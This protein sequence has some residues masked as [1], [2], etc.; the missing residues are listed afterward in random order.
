MSFF[1]ELAWRGFIQDSSDAKQVQE[2]KSGDAF[3]LG[4]DAT[5]PSIHIGHFIPIIA[6][7]HMAKAGLKPVILIGGATGAIG[8]PRESSER[9]LIAEEQVDNSVRRIQ[10][11]LDRVFARLGI[12]VTFVNNKD[13]LSGISFLNFLRDVG[14]HFPVATMI[15]KDVIKRRLNSDGISYT[16]FSYQLLQAY[17]F[18]HLNQKFGVKLQI[19]GSD[20][21]GNVTAGLDFI[22][23]KGGSG[24]SGFTVPLLTDSNGKKLGKSEGNALWIDAELFSPFQ[25]HQYFLNQSD[26]D[27]EGFLKVFTFKSESEISELLALAS[28]APEKRIVQNVVADSFVELIHGKDAVDHAKKSAEVLFSGAVQD[29]SD[30]DLLAIFAHVPSVSLSKEDLALASVLDLL[31]KSGAVKSRGD[32]KRLVTGGGVSI[33]GGRVEDAS[34]PLGSIERSIVIIRTGKKSYHLVKLQ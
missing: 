10:E 15:A 31:E 4:I 17:D 30:K 26:A 25:L 2:L 3:Y 22:R 27:S 20:Q 8:D 16:E 24:V 34:A 11:Q 19:G 14:K 33:N 32:G 5:A 23:R 12:A 6:A 18:Y 21:W 9:P 28:L 1:Q 7:I 29:M 13:W